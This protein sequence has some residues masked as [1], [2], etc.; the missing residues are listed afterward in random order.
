MSAKISGTFLRAALGPLQYAAGLVSSNKVLQG[1]EELGAPGLLGGLKRGISE[2]GDLVGLPATDIEAA[3]PV[4]QMAEL[5]A[6]LEVSQPNA[7]SAWRRYAGQFGFMDVIT[8]LTIDGRKPEIGLCLER[9]AKKLAADREL[10]EP[11]LSLA[12]DVTA[13]EELIVRCRN[14]LEDRD[15]LAKAYAKKRLRRVLAASIPA[16]VIAASL[17]VMVV[18]RSNRNRIDRAIGASDACSAEAAAGSLTFASKAQ[19]GA[20]EEAKGRCQAKLAAEKKQREEAA[21]ARELEEKAARAKTEHV[22]ACAKLAASVADGSFTEGGAPADLDAPTRALLA[23]LASKKL[24]PADAGPEDPTLP[25]GDTPSHAEL[26]KA[27]GAALVSDLALWT[28]KMDPSPASRRALEARRAE[29][30]QNGIIG[31][32]STA[33]K[34]AKEGLTTGKA[35]VMARAK[36]LCAVARALGTPGRASCSAVEKL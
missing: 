10:S 24:S 18:V 16:V 5:A 12:A 13:W 14:I 15:W 7:V 28:Q 21:R 3:M 34:T 2:V 25:C 26:E 23:R 9:V 20:L 29:L 30:P 31:L 35:D 36:R 11:L 32:A 19:L 17:T 8:A 4:A 22:E 33:E 27:L 6:R 1:I